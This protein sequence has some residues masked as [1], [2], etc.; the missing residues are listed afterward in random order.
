MVRRKSG[1]VVEE[2]VLLGA[3]SAPRWCRSS[4]F[5]SARGYNCNLQLGRTGS[6]LKRSD[7]QEGRPFASDDSGA[8]GF[9]PVV[10]PKKLGVH[11]PRIITSEPAV[12]ALEQES[13]INSLVSEHVLFCEQI[14]S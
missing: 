1:L 13:A 10:V 8:V 4:A 9:L 5:Q 2:L 12:D 7:K 14:L 3:L 6:Q 11:A